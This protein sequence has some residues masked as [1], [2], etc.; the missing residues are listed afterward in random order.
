MSINSISAVSSSMCCCSEPDFEELEIQRRLKAYGIDPTG[1]KSIDKAKLHALE[2]QKVKSNNAP[3]GGF[4]TISYAQE[5]Q[6]I[7]RKKER[8]YGTSK[9]QNRNDKKDI[10]KEDE[11][12]GRQILAII[13]LKKREQQDKLNSERLGLN[14]PMYKIKSK[15]YNTETYSTYKPQ[16]L[17]DFGQKVYEPYTKTRVVE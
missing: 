12:L 7:D 5:G 14:K 15:K 8:L 17:P 13:E 4:L 16:I 3:T 6:I 10:L 1:N 2:L 11:I 9:K